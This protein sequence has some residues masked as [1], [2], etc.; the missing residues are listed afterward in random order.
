VAVTPGQPLLKGRNITIQ[1][2]EADLGGGHASRYPGR[3]V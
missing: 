3:A 1:E 2:D